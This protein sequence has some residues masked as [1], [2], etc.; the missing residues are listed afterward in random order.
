MK[1]SHME[2]TFD[3]F[4]ILNATKFIEKQVYVYRHLPQPK[5]WGKAIIKQYF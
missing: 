4:C 5:G 3:K 2:E 1:G